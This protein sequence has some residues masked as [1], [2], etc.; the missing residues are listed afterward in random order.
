MPVAEDVWL[1]G[2]LPIHSEQLVP[3]NLPTDPFPFPYFC[4]A[5]TIPDGWG[6]E[7]FDAQSIASP[8]DRATNTGFLIATI[9]F[10]GSLH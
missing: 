3:T 10:D 1:D 5:L 7:S 2:K 8:K 4:N 9:E 6:T